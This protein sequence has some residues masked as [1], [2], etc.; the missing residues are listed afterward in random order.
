M[1]IRATR[2]LLVFFNF[3]TDWIK[4][5]GDCYKLKAG[6]IIDVQDDLPIIGQIEDI[7]V[8][9]GSTIILSVQQFHTI[10]EQHYRAYVLQGSSENVLIP[11][12]KLFLHS[13]IYI[14]RSQTL[15]HFVILPH[16]LC[17]L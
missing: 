15:H 8:V 1:D 13:P 9:D 6:V 5:D 12:S 7:Y 14:H 16:T 10:Y 11:L 17:T 4:K 2:L 3:R